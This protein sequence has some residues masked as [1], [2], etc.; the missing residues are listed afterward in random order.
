M[1]VPTVQSSECLSSNDDR[2]S[3]SMDKTRMTRGDETGQR[4]FAVL[5]SAEFCGVWK[6]K[7]LI[8]TRW[9]AHFAFDLVLHLTR[10]GH[11]NFG[12]S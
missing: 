7:S 2:A 5:S 11:H 9:F 6:L 4:S 3:A 10:F 1:N 12:I 8:L